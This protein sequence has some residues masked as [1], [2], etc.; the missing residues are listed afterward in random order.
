MKAVSRG[1][2]IDVD[3]LCQY[4]KPRAPSWCRR[5]RTRHNRT[6]PH[7]PIVF[8]VFL[9]LVLYCFISA[10]SSTPNRSQTVTY[11]MPLRARLRLSI[12]YYDQFIIKWSRGCNL[13]ADS[14]FTERSINQLKLPRTVFIYFN[15]RIY[16]FLFSRVNMK[17]SRYTQDLLPNL[18]MTVSH[19]NTFFYLFN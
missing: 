12:R 11:N 4:I 10:V 17:G 14:E 13:K 7:E 3:V 18:K 5:H 8:I 15:V 6:P 9:V 19:T 1:N 2:G 16:V